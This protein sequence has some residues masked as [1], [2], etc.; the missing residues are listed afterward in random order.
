MRTFLK[1]L[2]IVPLALLIVLFAVANRQSVR[3]SLDP[4]SR[5]VSVF[6]FDAPLFAVILAALATGILVG[7]FATWL[8]QGKHR[9]A[10][11]LLAKETEQLRAESATLRSMVTDEALAALPS[12]RS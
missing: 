10:K 8:A 7:G 5:D 6:A 1:A 3:L 11:R 4:A 2:L 9:K 12:R